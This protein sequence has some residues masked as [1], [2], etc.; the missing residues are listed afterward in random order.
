MNTLL[1]IEMETPSP[2]LLSLLLPVSGTQRNDVEF[3]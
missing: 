1:G 2:L 3:Y